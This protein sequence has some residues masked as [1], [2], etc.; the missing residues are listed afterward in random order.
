MNSA[1]SI[2]LAF[3]MAKA[4]VIAAV[5]SAYRRLY[6]SDFSGDQISRPRLCSICYGAGLAAFWALRVQP[7]EKPR[8]VVAIAIELGIAALKAL[9]RIRLPVLTERLIV[10][11]ADQ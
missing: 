1:D 8:H 3:S 7:S 2:P 5:Y 11:T 4:C 9:K 6:S 10:L